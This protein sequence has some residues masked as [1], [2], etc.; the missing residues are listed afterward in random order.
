MARYILKKQGVKDAKKINPATG[1][2]H[3]E[4]HNPF[5]GATNLVE[6]EYT[7]MS[8]HPGIAKDWLYKHSKDVYPHG[9]IHL[10]H[11]AP[12]PGDPAVKMSMKAPPYFDKIFAKENPAAMERL[13][14]R[15]KQYAIDHCDN[16]APSRL[17][18]KEKIIQQRISQYERK[19]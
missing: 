1:L 7:Q 2:K 17:A 11:F 8:T 13:V 9:E 15:R 14:E 4:V 12:F 5:T 18:A 10:G 19:L 16:Y 6:P 3:Y